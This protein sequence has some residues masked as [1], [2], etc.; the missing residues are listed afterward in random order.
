MLVIEESTIVRA[1]ILVKISA[2]LHKWQKVEL[3]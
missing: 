1:E 3:K 2:M